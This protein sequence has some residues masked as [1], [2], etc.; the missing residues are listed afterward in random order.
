MF[1]I[2]IIIYF[3]LYL[4]QTFSFLMPQNILSSN[5]KTPLKRKGDQFKEE[6]QSNSLQKNT[7]RDLVQVCDVTRLFIKQN[8]KRMERNIFLCPRQREKML[9]QYKQ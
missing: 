3:I 4:V 1:V 9:L 6:E 2:G 8:Q 5:K 7:E